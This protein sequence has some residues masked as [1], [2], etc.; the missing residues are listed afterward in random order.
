MTLNKWKKDEEEEVCPHIEV[1]NWQCKECNN[2][3]SQFGNVFDTY[4]G[5]VRTFMKVVYENDFLEDFLNA[6]ISSQNDGSSG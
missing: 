3:V 2:R 4:G 5:K 6:Y 1:E